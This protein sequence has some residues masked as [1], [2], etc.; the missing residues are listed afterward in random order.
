MTFT[1]FK[2]SLQQAAP[3]SL[4]VLLL[5]LW[6][7]GKGDWEKAHDLVNDLEGKDAAWVHAYL[8]RKEGDQSNASY[9]YHR[10]KANKPNYSLEQEWEEIVTAL[11]E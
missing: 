3:P 7:D 11:L 1:Q 4:N 9:W 6:H 8:H 10:A 2:E 5:S